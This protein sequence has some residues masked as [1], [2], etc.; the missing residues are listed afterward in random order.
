MPVQ[1]RVVRSD[2]GW[3]FRLRVGRRDR[4]T[5]KGV[6][7]RHGRCPMRSCNRGGPGGLRVWLDRQNFFAPDDDDR[8]GIVDRVRSLPLVEPK[9]LVHE[10]PRECRAFVVLVCPRARYYSARHYPARPRLRCFW[11]CCSS[12]FLLKRAWHPWGFS[13]H[14]STPREQSQYPKYK[15]FIGGADVHW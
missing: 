9:V 4:T 1:S 2:R 11:C 7:K 15:V 12:D 13:V 6:V 3:R 8:S 14:L 10:V 5:F